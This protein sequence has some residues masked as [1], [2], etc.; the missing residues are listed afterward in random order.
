MQ[1]NER[2][3]EGSQKQQSEPGWRKAKQS[4]PAEKVILFV[5]DSLFHPLDLGQSER[6]SVDN[7]KAINS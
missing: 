4:R 6:L 2:T 7:L 3:C 5:G 1:K